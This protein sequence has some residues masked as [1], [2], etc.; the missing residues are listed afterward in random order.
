MSGA[1]NTNIFKKYYLRNKEYKVYFRS[2]WEKGTFHYVVNR[3]EATVLT[4]EKANKLLNELKHSENY[5][6]IEKKEK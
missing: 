5:E 4:K 6:I 3:D 2:R 1:K